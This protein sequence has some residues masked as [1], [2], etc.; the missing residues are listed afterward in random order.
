M[1]EAYSVVV[2]GGIV[3]GFELAQVKA[4]VAKMFKLSDAQI[5]KMF[6]G[7]PV[8]I[9]RGVEKEQALKLRA[10]LTKAGAV[11][12]IKTMPAEKNT[13]VKAQAKVDGDASANAAPS[14]TPAITCPRCGHDQDYTTA[15]GKCKMD[16]SLHILR[17]ERKARARAVRAVARSTPCA[18]RKA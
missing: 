10:A 14:F 13:A 9:R 8:A 2:T 4:N 7:K 1:S 15:C 6:A 12:A 18:A 5:E 17:L 11:S 3:D 16:L